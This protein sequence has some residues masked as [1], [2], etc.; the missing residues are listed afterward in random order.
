MRIFSFLILTLMLFACASHVEESIFIDPKQVTVI[1][2]PYYKYIHTSVYPEFIIEKDKIKSA[3]VYA[4]FQIDSISLCDCHEKDSVSNLTIEKTLFFGG[5]F[6]CFYTN[7]YKYGI[8][9][10]F[11]TYCNEYFHKGIYKDKQKKWEKQTYIRIPGWIK[12]KFQNNKTLNICDTLKFRTL[13]NDI[14]IP[15]DTVTKTTEKIPLPF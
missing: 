8:A 12:I 2:L 7:R 15:I 14:I 11:Y 4:Y 1:P 9:N 13:Y 5:L 3:T 6:S 10:Q